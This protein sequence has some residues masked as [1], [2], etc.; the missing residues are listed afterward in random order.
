MEPQKDPNPNYLP[1][2]P[3]PQQGGD[4]IDLRELFKALWKGKW[5]II[6]TTFIFAIGSVL[7][8]LSLPNIYKADALLSKLVFEQAAKKT[9]QK[10]RGNYP[11]TVAI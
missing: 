3:N 1:Y 11:A 6:A 4:E 8:A 2:P 9:N 10:T 7:Y 5:I